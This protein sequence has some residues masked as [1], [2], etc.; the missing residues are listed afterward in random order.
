MR[1]LT[2]KDERIFEDGLGP[3]SRLLALARALG[4]DAERLEDASVAEWERWLLDTRRTAIGGKIEAV[5]ACPHCA[6]KVRFAFG[7]DELPLPE[8]APETALTVRDLADLE[9]SALTGEAALAFLGA[10]A[11]G[12]EEAVALRRLS[13]EARDCML[14]ALE[15]GSAGLGLDLAAECAACGGEIVLPFDVAA[16]LD[17]ELRAR[18]RRL[19]DDIHVIAS[20]YHWSEDAILALPRQRR[21]AYLE[22]IEAERL[23]PS[24]PS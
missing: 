12:I 20:A 21:L 24:V 7:I 22:R 2:G 18:A 17:D 11:E 4:E 23:T 8:K 1:H 3:V 16:F 5:A 6:T 19:L 13:S 9:R 10:R 15:A 14:A